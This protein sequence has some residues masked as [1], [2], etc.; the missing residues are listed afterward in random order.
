MRKAGLLRLLMFP[1]LMLTLAPLLLTQIAGR[2]S[3]FSF[4]VEG[5]LAE[6][7][8]V[9][10]AE[11]PAQEVVIGLAGHMTGQSCMCA[12]ICACVCCICCACGG[13][14][15]PRADVPSTAAGVAEASGPAG[16]AAVALLLT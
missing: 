3:P 13:Q 16:V 5:A 1:P 6:V 8:L 4:D 14:P 15:S 12:C 10:P 7:Y 9:V 2:A 11:M